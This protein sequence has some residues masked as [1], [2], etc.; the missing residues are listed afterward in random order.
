MLVQL[1]TRPGLGATATAVAGLRLQRRINTFNDA[2]FNTQLFDGEGFEERIQLSA[3]AYAEANPRDSVVPSLRVRTGQFL[4]CTP[5]AVATTT[6]VLR[7]RARLVAAAPASA[8]ATAALSKQLTLA[9]AGSA[10]IVGAV[11]L[12][13]EVFLATASSAV[14]TGVAD[15]RVY[16]PTY[17]LGYA[18][19]LGK[20][21]VAVTASS[22]R[23][24]A[25][26]RAVRA[27]VSAV[28]IAVRRV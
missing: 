25:A 16:R 12:R 14:A 20:V 11:S 26:A 24:A 27:T 13:L 6:A 9:V 22:I 21:N 17:E 10:T 23:P 3:A 1:Q 7:R 19:D 28:G 4:A 8:V 2:P 15:L 18:V 5:S